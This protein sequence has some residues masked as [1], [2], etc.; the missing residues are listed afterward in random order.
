MKRKGPRRVHPVVVKKK[1]RRYHA[2]SE[3]V[4][5]EIWIDAKL[6]GRGKLEAMIHEWLHLREW[7]LPES[8]VR[9]ISRA[10][11]AFLHKNHVRLIEPGNTPLDLE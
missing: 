5:R 10:L 9:R 4:L 8:D 2:W 6:T 3:N 11:T 1:L 7:A